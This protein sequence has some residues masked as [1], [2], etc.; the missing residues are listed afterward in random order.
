[1]RY[2]DPCHQM[3]CMLPRCSGW[4]VELN[5][6]TVRSHQK[7]QMN[8]RAE[9][10]FLV[11]MEDKL[12]ADV[13]GNMQGVHS[14]RLSYAIIRIYSPI[15][16]VL[17]LKPRRSFLIS[18]LIGS[19]RGN[20]KIYALSILQGAVKWCVLKPP[21]LHDNQNPSTPF[22]PSLPLPQNGRACCLIGGSLWLTGNCMCKERS[23]TNNYQDK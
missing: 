4:P 2:I 3:Q 19:Y 22:S 18:N 15:C 13:T 8:R 11:N 6:L 10:H 1:M 12:C 23:G 9:L 17:D 16:R 20:P 5:E 14:W 7:Q 21:T